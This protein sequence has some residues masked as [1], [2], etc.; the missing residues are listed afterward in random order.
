[1]GAGRPYQH[2][3]G[4]ARPSTGGES[5]TTGSFWWQAS[6][7][8]AGRPYHHGEG[9]ACP[10]PGGRSSISKSDW[11][12]VDELKAAR[13]YQH[14]QGR[15]RPMPGGGCVPGSARPRP[16]SPVCATAMAAGGRLHGWRT[17]AAATAK[18]QPCS[19]PLPCTAQGTDVMPTACD[20]TGP[21]LPP[22]L[23]TGSPDQ[24]ASCARD[25]DRHS[26]ISW[27]SCWH[28]L[29]LLARDSA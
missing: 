18:P 13:T 10:A 14:A 3:Q 17:Q 21:S 19:R 7:V 1:M 8:K 2:V 25:R 12:Q 15:A 20:S 28:G 27:Q 16:D 26:D 24:E 29:A 11:W 22:D 23:T 6:R 9:K 5:S 4:K